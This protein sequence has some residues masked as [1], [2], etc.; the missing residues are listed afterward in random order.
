MPLPDAFDPAVT[1]DLL[2]RLEALHPESQPRWDHRDA[3]WMVR[4][5]AETY[6]LASAPPP[7]LSLLHRLLN[8]T[9]LRWRVVSDRPF[10]ED[11]P[12][13]SAPVAADPATLNAG[14]NHLMMLIRAAHGMEARHMEGRLHPLHGRLSARQWSA[15]Y[16]KHLDHHLRQYGV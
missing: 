1:A 11:A 2:R 8:R 3:A 14:R 13:P 15:L 9:Y 4:H 12:G 6:E 16:W 5:C 10:R 7:R